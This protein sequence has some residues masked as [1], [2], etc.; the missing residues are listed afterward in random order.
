MTRAALGK[1]RE[2]RSGRIIMI[3]SVSGLVTPPAH[4][5]YSA[6]KHAME[7]LSNAL[8]HGVTR[9]TMPNRKAIA[10]PGLNARACAHHGVRIRR[11]EQ[12][13]G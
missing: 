6:S 2:R 13:G 5:A 4:G 8:R 9:D 12:P 7:G 1:M 11:P 3:S 10:Y